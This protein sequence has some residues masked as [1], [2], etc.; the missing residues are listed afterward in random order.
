MSMFSSIPFIGGTAGGSTL[1]GL[2]SAML[3]L[4]LII[5]FC[6]A[7]LVTFFVVLKKIRST[8]VIEI[9]QKTKRVRITRGEIKKDG[10][11]GIFKLFIGKLKKKLRQPQQEDMFVKGKKDLIM[12]MKDN[13]GMHHTLRI[14]TW[15]ELV[16]WHKVIYDK[17]ITGTNPHPS[18]L[19]DI[20]LLPNPHEDLQWLASQIAEAD[21]EFKD[22]KWWQ[23]PNVQILGTAF[24]CFMMFVISLIIIKRF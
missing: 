22:L 14:P 10:K 8:P 1:T 16:K 4:L 7:V 21:Q 5:L 9:N 19:S 20:Y 12:L 6:A 2:I 15:D 23:H 24:I 17:D 11:D 3:I 13:N 18:A